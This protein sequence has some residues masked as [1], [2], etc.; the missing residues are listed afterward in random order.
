MPA[1]RKKDSAAAAAAAE[2]PAAAADNGKK[3]VKKADPK[4]DKKAGDAEASFDGGEWG[5]INVYATGNADNKCALGYCIM[6]VRDV[7]KAVAWYQKVFGVKI[8][9]RPMDEWTEC[10]FGNTALSFHKTA[11]PAPAAGSSVGIAGP[12]FFIRDLDKFHAHA[13]KLG[14]KVMDEPKK[15]SWGGKKASYMDEDGIPISLVE[16]NMDDQ[17]KS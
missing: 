14:V 16:W 8:R 5:K 10:D 11:G 2:S 9:G 6:Y 17:L 15:E 1:K 3:D 12:G 13:V 7:P 4:K